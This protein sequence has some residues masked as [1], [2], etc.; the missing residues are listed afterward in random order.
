MLRVRLVS[1]LAPY[2]QDVV[3]TGH[4]RDE[5]GVLAFPN[6]QGAA[7]APEVLADH[8]R[9]TLTQLRVDAQGSAQAPRRALVL[10]DPPSA[11]AGEITDKGYV[12]QRAVLQRR[13]D[14]VEALHAVPTRADVIV[15]D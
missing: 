7:L 4:E 10:R 15:V 11:D 2:V 5:I 12:N 1:A 9:T 8:I 13:A 6:A 14:Q 3:V